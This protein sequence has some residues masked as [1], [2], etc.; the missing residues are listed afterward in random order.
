MK[1]RSACMRAPWTFELRDVDLPDTPPPGWLRLRVDA[2][3]ICGT[4]LSAVARALTPKPFG[5]ET[6]GTIEQLGHGVTGLETG[7]KI[8]LE[9]ASFC[10]RC[11]DCRN[12][13]VDLCNKAPNFWSQPAMG[14]S[15]RMMAPACCAVPYDALSPEVAALTEPAGVAYD[16]VKVA[17]VQLGDRV[18]VVGPGPIGLMAVALARY[19]G[20]ARLVCIG[21]SH[22][23]RRL[24]TARL[25]GAETVACDG[26][27][28]DLKDLARQFDHVL[29]T[30]PTSFIPPALSLL[31]CEGKL[32]YIGLAHGDATIAFNADDFHF[33]KLQLRASFASPA[34]YFPRVLS[35]FKAG[36]LPGQALISHVF[37]LARIAEAMT[38]GRDDKA[39]TLKIV[40]TNA[41]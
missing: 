32:T 39:G 11:A 9:S 35:L 20:A 34:V 16:T 12:G 29:M 25:L 15:E 36:I 1:T 19:A 28:S 31:G 26:A 30:A 24:A 38:V 10:G 7:Q 22:S 13:R 27:L 18:C 23:A 33:R 2:C 14:L 37:P 4:D 41:P 6:A 3:G 5:H 8:V 21:R 40:V 17:G